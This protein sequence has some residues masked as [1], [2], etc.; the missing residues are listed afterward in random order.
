MEHAIVTYSFGD[1]IV[2]GLG[3]DLIRLCELM[4]YCKQTGK[5]FTILGP[6]DNWQLVPATSTDNV[7]RCWLYYFKPSIPIDWT[8]SNPRITESDI[9]ES[10]KLN[11]T[12]SNP[13]EYFS[14][15]LKKIYQPT[16]RM[17]GL[18]TVA[19]KNFE[20][21]TPDNYVA[22]HVRRGDKTAGPWAEGLALELDL[23]LDAI[24]QIEL[25][26][27]IKYLYVATDSDSVITQL[28]N[29]K[30]PHDLEIVYDPTEIRNDGYVYK[31][32]QGIMV[33]SDKEIEIITFMKNIDLL[34][35]AKEII[36]SR[37]SFFFIVAELLRGRR[38]ISLSDNLLYRVN[39]Y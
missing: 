31:L 14:Y 21:L 16:D 17:I 7:G 27:E 2:N 10:K 13:F 6:G 11:I 33:D 4:Y 32:Y 34:V 29:K 12:E 25:G 39:F 8:G 5:I 3:A 35:G 15:L 19:K 24:G 28:Q 38:G 1:F 26:P 20:F 30:I 18:R 36:G 9:A 37:M 23:Y 22:I